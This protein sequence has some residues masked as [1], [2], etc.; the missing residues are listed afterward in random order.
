MWNHL[1]NWK[2]NYTKKTTLV[3]LLYMITSGQYEMLNSA[4]YSNFLSHPKEPKIAQMHTLV[5][6]SVNDTGPALA[7]NGCV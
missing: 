1:R 4:I 3:L 7:Y 2:T 5:P 6:C